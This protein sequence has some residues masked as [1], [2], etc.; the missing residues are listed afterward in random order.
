MDLIFAELA[1]EARA[2]NLFVMFRR[3]PMILNGFEGS[4]PRRAEV[5]NLINHRQTTPLS[6]VFA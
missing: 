2:Y 5:L 4:Q 1:S 3:C 6:Y